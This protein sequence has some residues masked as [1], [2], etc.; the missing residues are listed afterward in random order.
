MPQGVFYKQNPFEMDV[1]RFRPRKHI[2][3]GLHEQGR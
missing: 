1:S 3:K 2:D